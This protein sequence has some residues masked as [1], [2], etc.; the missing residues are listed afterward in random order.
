ML[1]LSETRARESASYYALVLTGPSGKQY[2]GP[3]W[4]TKDAAIRSQAR[5][6]SSSRYFSIR[7][8]YRLHVHPKPSLPASLE[9]QKEGAADSASVKERA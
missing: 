3:A 4:A 6:I 9:S 8:L 2:V 1:T 7:P 5:I